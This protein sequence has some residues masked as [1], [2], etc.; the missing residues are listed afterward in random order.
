MSAALLATNAEA[1]GKDSAY[2]RAYRGAALLIHNS[3]GPSTGLGSLML[4]RIGF[5]EVEI[6]SYKAEAELARM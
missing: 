3:C 6:A 5:S 2:G 4:R 1:M